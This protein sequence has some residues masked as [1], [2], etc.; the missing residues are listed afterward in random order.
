VGLARSPRRTAALDHL[1]AFDNGGASSGSI[2]RI[3]WPLETEAAADFAF[4]FGMAAPHRNDMPVGAALGPDKTTM[5]PSSHPA[6]IRRTSPSALRH[7]PTFFLLTEPS[8]QLFKM[9]EPRS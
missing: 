5:R 9:L 8:A 1:A 6:V 7:C 2:Q 4:F 3:L